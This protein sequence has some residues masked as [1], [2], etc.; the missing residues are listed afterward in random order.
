LHAGAAWSGSSDLN[1]YCSFSALFSRAEVS[2]AVDA[3]HKTLKAHHSLGLVRI[4]LEEILL[5]GNVAEAQVRR[6][7]TGAP[8]QSALHRVNLDPFLDLDLVM[9]YAT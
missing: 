1:A 6:Q 4:R 3:K 2:G 9:L 7:C 8:S 5:V